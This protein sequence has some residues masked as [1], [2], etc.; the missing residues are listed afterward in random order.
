MPIIN[1]AFSGAVPK[2]TMQTRLPAVA[3]QFYPATASTLASDIRALLALG[4]AKVTR[5]H[6]ETILPKAL[7]VP[8]AGY[9]YSGRIAAMAYALLLPW[10]ECIRRVVLLGPAHRLSIQGLAAP[11]VASF[12]TPLGAIP[13]DHSAINKAKQEANLQS[14]DAAHAQEHAIEVQLPFLQ[15]LLNTFSLVPL[16]VGQASTQEVAQVLDSLWGGEETLIVISSDLSHYLTHEESAIKDRATVSDILSG[17]LLT[18]SAQ[19]CGAI[20]INGLLQIASRKA[21]QPCLLDQCT[22][23]DVTQDYSRVV[24]YAA[25]AFMSAPLLSNTLMSA[26]MEGIGR[27]LLSRATNAIAHHLGLSA[28]EE[29]PYCAALYLLG[30]SFVTLTQNQG[31][32][33]GCI[34][35]LHP[36]RTLEADVRANAIA[37]ASH[38]P[39]FPPLTAQELPHTTIEVSMLSPA[40]ALLFT[41]EADV[42]RQLR[43]H[44][45]GIIF[46]HGSRQATFLPQVWKSLP[47]P[48]QFLVA[49]KKKAGFPADFWDKSVSL[50]RYTVH[51]WAR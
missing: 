40:Q 29:E 24:G 41:D 27:A 13:I 39:R 6:Q 25:L 21:L 28:K 45:D 7:I 11:T 48:D 20:P 12:T 5:S 36:H 46:G 23:G 4:Y 37:A 49:L 3:G 43:P 51:K 15:V 47:T 18:S 32:L 42:L 14:N 17:Y 38:D 30:A 2:S 8:H 1:S 10:R 35:S 19:A 22:S 9:V 34:G 44:I 33:R 16:L 26:Q 31:Q 50:Q